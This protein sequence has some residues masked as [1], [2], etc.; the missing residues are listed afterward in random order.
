M[1]LISNTAINTDPFK[2]LQSP[3]PKSGAKS[4]RP[5]GFNFGRYGPMRPSIPSYCDMLQCSKH[6][7]EKN[8]PW[9]DSNLQSPD[10]KSGALSIRPHGLSVRRYGPMRPR[11]PSY[12][13]MLQCSLWLKTTLFSL[14]SKIFE[15]N[16]VAFY[17]LHWFLSEKSFLQLL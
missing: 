9:Q 14:P 8:R 16:S 3:D 15:K 7:S 11:T 10:P 1:S 4:I 5:N 13:D 2:S 6:F 12:Q 17:L